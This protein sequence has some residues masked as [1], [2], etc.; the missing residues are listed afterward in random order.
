MDRQLEIELLDELRGLSA[1]RSFFMDKEIH[2]SPVECYTS[3]DRFSKE[4]QAIFKAM[5]N[6]AAH[7]SQLA[8]PGSYLT[9][10]LVGTPVLVARNKAGEVNAFVNVCR[11]RGARLVGE[12]AGCKHVFACPYHGWSWDNSGSLRGIPHQDP[13]FPGIDRAQYGL[14]RLPVVERLGLIWVVPDLDAEVDFDHLIDPLE[15]DFKWMGMDGMAIAATDELTSKANWKLL[16]EGGIEAYHFRVTHKNTIGP[17]FMDNLSSYRML[18]P[19]MRS[20][21]PRVA[22][23]ELGDVDQADWSIRDTTNVLYSLMPTDQF[24]LMQDHVAWIRADPLSAGETRMRISTL[25]PADDLTPDRQEHWARNHAITMATL[26]E[27]FDVNEAVQSGLET[28]VNTEL[29]FGRFESALHRFNVE[30]EDRI[31][32]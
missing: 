3:E 32:L 6:I 15:A 25:V 19:H 7:S 29:T 31:G 21:L 11:H 22:V 27:D 4:K 26:Q 24:L 28:G 12:E 23:G 16:V 1:E 8:E 2:R 9:V 18:G 17:H 13:G 5:P 10:S 20:I 30:V 14:K